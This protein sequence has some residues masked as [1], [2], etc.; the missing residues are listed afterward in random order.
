MKPSPEVR[1]PENMN[2]KSCAYC[3]RVIFWAPNTPRPKN[4]CKCSYRYMRMGVSG[5]Q[6][7]NTSRH[8]TGKMLKEYLVEKMAFIEDDEHYAFMLSTTLLDP[9]KI[10]KADAKRAKEIAN[11]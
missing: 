6:T 7:S 8:T 5:T 1:L 2:E 9:V 4:R 3:G 11:V 10:A